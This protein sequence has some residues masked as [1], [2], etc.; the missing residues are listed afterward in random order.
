MQLGLKELKKAIEAFKE[1]DKEPT[2]IIIGYKT[3]ARLMKE[4]KFIDQ[5]SK[6]TENPMVRY[7]QGIKIKMVTEKH[8]L[9]IE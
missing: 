2:K 4:E 1:T 6:D 5:L 3:Y 9:K 7:Y 8:Y